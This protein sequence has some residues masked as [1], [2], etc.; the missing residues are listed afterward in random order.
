L[1]VKER[2]YGLKDEGTTQVKELS[3]DVV[4]EVSSLSERYDEIMKALSD[5]VATLEASAVIVKDTLK[6][7]HKQIQKIDTAKVDEKALGKIQKQTAEAI[8]LLEGLTGELDMQKKAIEDT[9]KR[10]EE[11]TAKLS[12]AVETIKS[13]EASRQAILKKLSK[14]KLEKETFE[15]FLKGDRLGYESAVSPMKKELDSVKMDI[16]RL[17]H[18]VDML[19]RSIQLLGSE[20]RLPDTRPVGEKAGEALSP[21]SG[22]II[23]QEIAE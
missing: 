22:G 8:K 7:Q 23:E 20:N 18:Q 4:E 10:Q 11:E 2:V 17:Q 21:G 9:L 15:E 6:K 1:D 16:G 19:G 13:G 12:Q 3:E 5:R 14:N